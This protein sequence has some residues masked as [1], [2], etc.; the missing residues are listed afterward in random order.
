MK[1]HYRGKY[2]LDPNSLPVAE[3]KEGAIQ[4]EEAASTQEL[5]KKANIAAFILLILLLIPI[6]MLHRLKADSFAFWIGCLLSLFCALPHE[7]L[8]AF[9]FKEDVY[10]Y[11]N[12]RQGMLFVIG[13]EPM[14]KGRFIFLSL[15]PNLVFGLVPYLLGLIYPS[16]SL[17]LGLGWSSL[18]MGTGDYINVYHALKQMPKGALT[19]MSGF[20][21]YWFMPNKK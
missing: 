21:S 19:Y 1:L 7:L 15:L 8:H 5:A 9:C 16:L 4:F 2:D 13:T 6:V 12:L 18:A 14:S 17:L 3:E 11:T 10:L 20:H